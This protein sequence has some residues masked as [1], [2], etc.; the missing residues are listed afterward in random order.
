VNVYAFCADAIS[1][2][3]LGYIAYVIFGQLAIL[4][5]W[6]LRWRWIRNPWFR[7]SHVA[8][9][10]TVAVE[11]YYNFECPLTTWEL[12][13]RVWAGQLPENF[14]NMGGQWEL[15]DMSFIGRI[16]RD[17]F[18]FDSSWDNVITNSY[19]GF[20]GLVLATLVLVPPRFRRPA[21]LA[22]PP[23]ND[24]PGF[25]WERSSG[26]VPTSPRLP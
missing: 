23:M 1:A 12:N 2:L 6:P 11:A 4:I 20:A 18:F 19:Y 14:R 10:A 24:T 16:V 22:A 21:R 13:L 9:I 7:T 17:A 3:H 8:M 15:E 26:E 25:A 5:G